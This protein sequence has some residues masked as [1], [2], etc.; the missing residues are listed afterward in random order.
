MGARLV[1]S[2]LALALSVGCAA[3]DP[4]EE[5]FQPMGDFRL[6]FNIV[7]ANEVT[8]GPF[9][10][11]AT[12]E[13]LAATVRA[14]LEKRLA[15]YNGDGLYHVGARVEGYVLAQT[16]I[17][18]VATPRSI[19]VLAVQVWDDATQEKLTETPA[20]IIA[21]E[22]IDSGPPLVGSGLLKSRE[23]QLANLS[24]NAAY[25]IEQLLRRNE[26]TWFGP[27]E[28]RA[29]IPFDRASRGPDGKLLETVDNLEDAEGGALPTDGS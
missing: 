13:E 10:R 8:Q 7:S 12:E 6:G 2:A 27:K 9:S 19:M 17:P 24:R 4:D 22:G 20:R 5:P 28:G 18:L 14:D 23:T 3:K 1:L 25:Q 11:D 21:F 16:G 15:R 29:R 26:E